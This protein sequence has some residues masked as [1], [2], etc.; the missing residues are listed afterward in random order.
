[1]RE[2]VADPLRRERMQRVKAAFTTRRMNVDDLFAD[3]QV[4][5]LLSG[6]VRP[7]AGDVVLARVDRIG[8]H[9]RIELT[10]GRR[11]RLHVGDE[12]LV[13]YGD[14]YATD[15][16]ESYVPIRL[17]RTSLVA[18]GGIASTVQSRSGAVRRATT[19]T[20]LG[21]LGDRY[22]M[23][24][25]ISQ[26]ALDTSPPC[27]ERPSTIAVFGTAMNS[28]KTTTVESLV[29][30]VWLAGGMPGAAKATGTG[31]GADYWVMTDAGAHCV[32]DFTDI[33][34][35]TTFRIPFEVVE[36]GFVQLVDHLT[37]EGCS[38]IVIEIADGLFQTETA[39]LLRSEIFREYVD[40][41]IFAASDAMGAL[42]GSRHLLDLDMPVRCV[43]GLLTRS[44]L[45]HREAADHCPVPVIATP[46]LSDPDIASV[47]FKGNDIDLEQLEALA[48]RV[49]VDDEVDLEAAPISLVEPGIGGFA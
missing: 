44:P 37:N 9:G 24:I 47:L 8:Q 29:R 5:T 28:G 17:G 26:F 35:P 25:N 10:N 31:S 4:P 30:G 18:S 3:G 40:G 34:L 48:Q 45:A 43:S 15:Q 13:V 7:R 16:F 1:M 12:I 32:A 27:V 39:Q 46:R 38:D 41:V 20:A 14:R 36:A 21:L 2:T 42:A 23:P 6:A 19:I 11:A 33:G 22:G 49:E